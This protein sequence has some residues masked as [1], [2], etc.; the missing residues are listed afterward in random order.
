MSTVGAFSVVLTFIIVL[1]GV[2]TFLTLIGFVVGLATDNHRIKWGK[3]ALGLF[4]S[5][6]ALILIGALI[7]SSEVNTSNSED[8]EAVEQSAS[9]ASENI[10]S[11]DVD[12]SAYDGFE[13]VEGR[14]SDRDSED[15]PLEYVRDILGGSARSID[16]YDD[17]QEDIINVQIDKD[18][19]L[20][21][22][23]I[24]FYNKYDSYNANNWKEKLDSIQAEL[25]EDDSLFVQEEGTNLQ[26][27][28]VTSG[29]SVLGEVTMD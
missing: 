8:T 13:D 2:A 14:T 23:L 9:G 4:G 25:P 27:N 22:G 6:G 29:G 19:E 7:N 17:D 15:E 21:H 5:M 18:S 24:A 11:F 3:I 1:L 12:S 26:Y 10:G 28:G 16:W 20:Y